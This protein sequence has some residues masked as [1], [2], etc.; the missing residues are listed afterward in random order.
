MKVVLKRVY[1]SASVE[2]GTRVLVDRLWPRGIAKDKMNIDLWLK[3]IAPS[4]AQR[5]RV[6]GKPEDWGEFCSAYAAELESETAQAAAKELMAPV[7][8]GKVT[9]LYAARNEERNNAVA[10]KI[11]L[12]RQKKGRR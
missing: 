1:E 5:K 6:H 11:W 9:L 12:E 10:L 7:K 3:D 8:R 4:D 2:D